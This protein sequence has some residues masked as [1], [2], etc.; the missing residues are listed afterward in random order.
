MTDAITAYHARMLRVLDHIDRHLDDTLDLETLAGVAAFSKHHFHRQFSALLGIGVSRYVQ[1]LRMKRAAYRLAYRE[2]PVTEIALDTGY[3]APES[4]TRAFRTM[5]GQAPGEFRKLPAWESW[6]Q[7]CGPLANPRSFQMTTPTPDQVEIV[8]TDAASVAV[9][10][11]RGDPARIGD[12]IQRFIA[13]RRATGLT[14]KVSATYNIFHSDPATTAPEDYRLDLCA[15]T[16]R[17]VAPN[18]D[19][20]VP[21]E[22]PAGRAARLTITGSSDDLGPAADWLY[23]EWL[24]ASGE[25]PRDFPFYCR[26]VSFFPDVPEHEAVTELYLPL[27]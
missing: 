17:P 9:L 8:T 13:W 18:D 12:T 2:T 10:T 19:G 11:H 4:F 15:A 23:R 14:P 3:E 25:E 27:A 6:L 16:D 5:F 22:I 21:G 1:L 7:A 26:R 20:V 24:P